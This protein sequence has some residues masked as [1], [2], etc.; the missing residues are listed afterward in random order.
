MTHS[1]QDGKITFLANEGEQLYF[2]QSVEEGTRY[3]SINIIS[4]EEDET[5]LLILFLYLYI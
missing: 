2:L 4:I 1:D 3:F 5:A